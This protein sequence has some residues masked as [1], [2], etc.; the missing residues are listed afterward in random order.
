MTTVLDPQT[1]RSRRR[2]VRVSRAEVRECDGA[3]NHHPRG[4]TGAVRGGAE[5][6]VDT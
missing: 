6:T 3:Y 1:M 2:V 4:C 5:I